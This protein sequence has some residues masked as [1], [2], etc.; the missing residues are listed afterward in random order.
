MTT[1]QIAHQLNIDPA[2]IT[3]AMR[4]EIIETIV[5]AGKHSRL[6]HLERVVAYHIIH[7]N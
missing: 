4:A 6:S 7:R 5:P 1:T 3:E 2:M